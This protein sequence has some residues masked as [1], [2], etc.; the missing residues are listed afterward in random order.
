VGA[1]AASVISQGIGNFL[2]VGSMGL[3]GKLGGD[4]WFSVMAK[5]SNVV[6]QSG[7]QLWVLSGYRQRA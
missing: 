6:V 5:A 4:F 2:V 7:S 1:H 3:G